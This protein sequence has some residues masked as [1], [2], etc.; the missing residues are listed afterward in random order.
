VLVRE[1][2][3]AELDDQSNRLREGVA[4]D[5]LEKFIANYLSAR[6]RDRPG[7]G[8]AAAALLPELA[9]EPLA[10]RRACA[11]SIAGA[12]REIAAALPSQTRDPGAVAL[13]VYATLIGALQLARAVK[14]TPLSGRVLAAGVDAACALIEV[15]EDEDGS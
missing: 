15:R 13:G 9:R 14:G 1:S 10:T 3:T 7:K 8:C 11:E 2:V 12:V 5:G 6:H 4:T